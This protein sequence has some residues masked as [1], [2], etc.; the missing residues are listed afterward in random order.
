MKQRTIEFRS[1][2]GT[3]MYSHEELDKLDSDGTIHIMDIIKPNNP[4]KMIVTMWTGLHDRNGK[5]IFEGDILDADGTKCTV[6]HNER[7]ASFC[8]KCAYHY[9]YFDDDCTVDN[10]TVLGNIFETQNLIA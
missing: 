1:W 9:Q 5:K 3:K 4:D 8:M 7:N 2:D 6:I 10:I